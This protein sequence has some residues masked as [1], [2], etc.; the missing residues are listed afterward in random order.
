VEHTIWI[1]LSLLLITPSQAVSSESSS[2]KS[3]LGKGAAYAH[4]PVIRAEQ[5]LE[6]WK[7][8]LEGINQEIEQRATKKASSDKYNNSTDADLIELRD[9]YTRRVERSEGV[10]EN[11]LKREGELLDRMKQE[12]IKIANQELESNRLER[13]ITNQTLFA[14]AF[15]ATLLTAGHL[16]YNWKQKNAVTSTGQAKD[17]TEVK[18]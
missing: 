9:E 11:E 14:I 2:T 10:L 16:I 5:Y 1:S 18:K 12:G 8:A 13:Q 7:K 17:Q 15:V 3:T 4:R 6:G